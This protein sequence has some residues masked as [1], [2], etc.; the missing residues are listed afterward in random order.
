MQLLTANNPRLFEHWSMS[1]REL[2]ELDVK[3]INEILSWNKLI[4]AEKDMDNSSILYM[5]ERFKHA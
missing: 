5:L 1:Y 2:S 4:N 3:V